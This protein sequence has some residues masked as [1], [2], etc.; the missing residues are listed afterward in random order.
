MRLKIYFLNMFL[1]LLFSSNLLE[2]QTTLTDGDIVVTR[3]GMDDPDA[4]SVLFL[5]DVDG[6]TEFYM[7]NEAW[8]GS[9]LTVNSYTVKMVVNS[10][11]SAG[12]EMHVNTDDFVITFTS[13]TDASTL[14]SMTSV[15]AYD[16]AAAGTNFLNAAGDN[17]FIYQGSSATNPSASDFISGITANSGV[18][19][20]SGNAWQTSASSSSTYIIDDK[21]NGVNG[22]FGLYPYGVNT[23]V[24]NARYKVTALHSGDKETLLAA[25]MDIT[26]W[27]FDNSVVYD[28]A[29]TAFTVTPTLPSS[30]LTGT[31]TISG[32]TTFG[33][34]LTANVSG[35]NN[36]GTL[37]YQWKRAD[38]N[39]D[40][41]TASTYTL[42]E[43]DVATSISVEVTSSVESGSI[44][45]AETVDIAKANQAAPAQPTVASKTHN[46]ITL[47]VIAGCEYAINGGTWQAS[48]E[49]TSLTANTQYSF[50]QRLTET[51]THNASDASGATN[52][53]TQIE[54]GD[55][56]NGYFFDES[57]WD[58]TSG[59]LIFSGNSVSTEGNND[60]TLAFIGFNE[61]LVTGKKLTLNFSFGNVINFATTGWAGVSLY[62][63]GSSGTEQVFIG[64]LGNK[65][66]WGIGGATLDSEVS[67]SKTS[68]SVDVE[69]TYVY[70]S[71]AWILTV[72]GEQQSGTMDANLAF[73]TL[74]IGA[75]VNN[76]ADIAIVN[77][78]GAIADVA[79]LTG[80]VTINGTTT[81]GEDL[82]ANVSG[83]NNTGTL[84]YQWK[85]DDVNIDAATASTYT[86]VEA[87][88]A[89]SISVEVTSSV[90]SGSISSTGTAAIARADQVTPAQA[91]VSDKTSNSITLDIVTGGEY[92]INGGAWQASAEFT[93]L[94]ANTQYSLTQRL[95]ET[96]THNASDASVALDVTTD[97]ATSVSENV[98][99][100]E[101]R[102]FPNPASELLTV[103]NIQNGSQVML[104]DVAGNLVL[105]HEVYGTELTLNV[106]EL[107]SGIYIIK[108]GSNTTRV[109][110]K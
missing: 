67:F 55:L 3:I 42:V 18:K 95:A 26:N 24:D 52:I 75:D 25:I 97:I 54:Q 37:G 47:D 23:E 53:T 41:A 83:D 36:T 40:A 105:K 82:T 51:S 99:A 49:F 27:E 15:G 28:P 61:S 89:T 100:E 69:F 94:D 79:A 19:G 71:G 72:D 56:Y 39:I 68:P 59:Q 108:V 66:N 7:T 22:W 103:S 58:I 5:V 81:Y 4:F 107:N 92:A 11:I 102:V 17:I 64:S 84:S 48:S 9:A 60:M 34:E 73:N 93:G 21:T 63:G 1:I 29:S 110:I 12:E 32:T 43:A 10:T 33:E 87:D 76:N 44:L 35:D 57:S 13:G 104:F 98:A 85:R 38:V 46:S 80:T 88:I 31:V 6:T 96:S 91:T 106:G 30:T 70:H 90:E 20:T 2:A 74:R 8:T 14:I 50:T 86:L 65:A 109:V 101:L 78:S 62:T 45:S 16:L 77:V